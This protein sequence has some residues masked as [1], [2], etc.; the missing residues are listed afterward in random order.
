MSKPKTHFFLVVDRS[1]SMG[2]YINETISD[3]NEKV[4]QYKSEDGDEMEVL[5]SFLSFNH[6]VDEHWWCKPVSNLQ[7]IT[8]ETY[9]PS[10][11]T[12]LNDAVAYTIGKINESVTLGEDDAGV[13]IIITDGW[14]NAS[15]EFPGR[16]NPEIAKMVKALQEVKN[17]DGEK[18]WTVTYMGANQNVEQ[19]SRDFAIPAANCAL[20]STQSSDH[21]QHANRTFNRQQADYMRA[22]KVRCAAKSAG[23]VAFQAYQQSD[24][25]KKATSFMNKD[26]EVADLTELDDKDKK[27]M[28][29]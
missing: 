9:R 21:V 13:L 20:Y 19:V 11:S 4:Q 26:A 16:G 27:K 14:E 10:G 7:E 22:R 23:S 15:E 24:D 2:S 3:F 17:K 8:R 18:Q 12:A 1:S 5:C 29:S 28:E 6:H 25:A